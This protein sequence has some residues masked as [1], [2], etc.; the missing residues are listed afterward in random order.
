MM[1]SEKLWDSGFLLP[2]NSMDCRTQHILKTKHVSRL[3]HSCTAKLVV[4]GVH[5]IY[6][7]QSSLLS[8]D[9]NLC[10]SRKTELHLIMLLLLCKVRKEEE[11]KKAV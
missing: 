5:F 1:S 9:F 4:R 10:G 7:P 6:R 2:F 3:A 8:L 11:K